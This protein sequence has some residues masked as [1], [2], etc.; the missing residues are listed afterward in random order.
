MARPREFDETQVVA[1]ALEQFS[2]H[3]YAGTTVQD[4]REAT[5]VGK[6]S[7]YGAFGDKHDLY[8]QAFRQYCA[9]RLDGLR[10]ELMGPDAGARQRLTDHIR[11]QAA[12]ATDSPRGCFLASAAA[13]LAEH[14]PAVA[15]LAQRTIDGYAHLIG[16]C[17]RQAQRHRNVDPDHDPEALAAAVL[18]V[19]R[20]IE[21]LGRTRRSRSFMQSAAD[22]AISLLAAPAA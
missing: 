21:A 10:A 6:S 14:D 12:G 22:T 1:A 2:S 16:R 20:G 7:L 5:G 8:L 11:R 19:L 18:T 9:D 13:E 15:Q 17:I 4:L 3:G